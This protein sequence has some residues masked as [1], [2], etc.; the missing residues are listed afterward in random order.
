MRPQQWS[1]N[2]FVLAPLAFA[3]GDRRAAHALAQSDVLHVLAA[4]AAFSLGASA[5]YLLNDVLDAE[6]DRAHPEKCRRPIASGEL[7]PGTALIASGG[8]VAAALLLALFGAGNPAVAGVVAAYVVVNL[9]YSLR[10]KRVVLLDVFCI[11]L[12]FLLRVVAGGLAAAADVSHWILL[13]TFFLALFLALNK[14]RSEIVLL[15]ERSASHRA[16]LEQYSVPFV[17]QLVTVLAAATLVCYALYTVDDATTAKFGDDNGL[18]WSVPFV[19]FGLARYMLLVQ[20][21]AAGGNPTRVF[22]GGDT[23]F[24]A[25]TL[26]W[27]AVVA[28]AILGKL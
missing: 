5:V 4:F 1:K 6:S 10:L 3:L 8:C 2:V 14:R 11:A 21:G 18:V 23:L 17:D 26:C 25:N 27:G 7:A 13:C 22:L 12:G 19:V 24:L 28:L 20:N 9:A 15:G 16:I